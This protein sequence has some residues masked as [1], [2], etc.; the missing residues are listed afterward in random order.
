MLKETIRIFRQ[1]PAF[2]NLRLNRV[3]KNSKLGDP[4]CQFFLNLD[5]NSEAKL[6][7]LTIDHNKQTFVAFSLFASLDFA[8]ALVQRKPEVVVFTS[9]ALSTQGND[10]KIA[11]LLGVTDAEWDEL[12][13]S[14]AQK[15]DKLVKKLL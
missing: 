12:E 5:H 6:F 3:G 13:V 15:F 4:N 1:D 10:E 7:A 9:F 14:L 2:Q 8:T 11:S